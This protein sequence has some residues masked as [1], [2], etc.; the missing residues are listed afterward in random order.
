MLDEELF[1]KF[2]NKGFVG[3][4]M[5]PAF[6]SYKTLLECIEDFKIN[7]PLK[8]KKWRYRNMNKKKSL[9]QKD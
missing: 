8:W 2:K 1:E 5:S 9:R 7:A 4:I 6:L 3:D